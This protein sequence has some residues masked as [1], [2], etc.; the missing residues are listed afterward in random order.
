MIILAIDPGIASLGY[1]VVRHHL[2]HEPEILTYGC[3]HTSARLLRQ[4]RF[5]SLFASLVDIARLYSPT[6]MVIE[7]LFFAKNIKTALVVGES[8]G[9]VLLLAGQLSIPVEEFT[10]LQVKQAISGFG[11][12]PKGQVQRMVQYIFKMKELPSPDDAAD[13][14]A[15]AFTYMQNARFQDTARGKLP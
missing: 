12:A 3:L 8:R 11:R 4:Q 1:A 13:A 7:K 15:L 14:L 6:V 10:P 2:H 5:A 9:V